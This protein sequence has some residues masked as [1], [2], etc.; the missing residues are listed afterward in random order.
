MDNELTQF[1]IEAILGPDSESFETFITILRSSE[2]ANSAVDMMKQKDPNAFVLKI[3][4]FLSSSHVDIDSREKCAELLSNLL[5]DDDLCT[6]RNLS[7]STQSSIKSFLLNPIINLGESKFIIK[8][9]CDTMYKL[10][11]SLLPDNNWPEL[12]PFLYQCLTDSNN[13]FKASAFLI[14]ADLAGDLG[15]TIVVPSAKTLHSLFR[16]TLNDDTIDLNV[17]IA[18]VSAVIRFIQRYAEFK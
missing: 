17:R 11:A 10:A 7:I 16:N 1:E 9:R 18:A 13:Y 12:L 2:A 8:G 4:N 5:N 15:E 14:F 3:L 6:W